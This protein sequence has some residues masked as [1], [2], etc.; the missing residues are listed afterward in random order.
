MTTTT[1]AERTAVLLPTGTWDIDPSHSQVEF[2][3]RHLMVSKVKGHFGRFQGTITV[4]DDP[5]AAA[6]EATI[7]VASIDTNDPQR[8]TH[9]RSAD[10]L[11]VEHHPTA[12][13]VSRGVRP[14]GKDYVVSGDLTLHG[15]TRPVDLRLE[16]NG[17]GEDPYGGTRAGFSATAEV[18]RRDF[19]IDISMPLA[20][21]GVVVGDKITLTLAIQAVAR[22]AS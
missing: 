11:D 6:V 16:F 1:T 15:V 5:L 19:G 17:V 7:D 13:F 2:S 14:A 12:T 10:F 9:L 3:V 18:N 20:N 22:A 21:G 4:G 8:D